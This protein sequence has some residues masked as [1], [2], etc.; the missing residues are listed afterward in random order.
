MLNPFP[1]DFEMDLSEA[2]KGLQPTFLDDSTRK[3]ASETL[4]QLVT[5]NKVTA[6][7]AKLLFSFAEAR[8]E[9]DLCFDS[10][11]GLIEHL[12]EKQLLPKTE[13]EPLLVNLVTDCSSRHVPTKRLV[14]YQLLQQASPLFHHFFPEAIVPVFLHGIKWEKDPQCIMILFDLIAKAS[15]HTRFT[16]ELFEAAFRYFPITYKTPPNKPVLIRTE[17]LKDALKRVLSLNPFLELLLPKLGEKILLWPNSARTDALHIIKSVLINDSSP[18]LIEIKNLITS[19]LTDSASDEPLRRLALDCIAN[20]NTSTW[21]YLFLDDCFNALEFGSN[22]MAPIVPLLFRAIGVFDAFVVERLSKCCM[23]ESSVFEG[24]WLSLAVVL[25]EGC[26]VDITNLVERAIALLWNSGSTLHTR[27]MIR[28]L[29]AMTKHLDDPTSILNVLVSIPVDEQVIK[30]DLVNFFRQTA[31]RFTNLHSFIQLHSN[32]TFVHQMV[33]VD[34]YFQVLKTENEEDLETVAKLCLISQNI[35]SIINVIERSSASKLLTPHIQQAILS[36]VPQLGVSEQES[37]LKKTEFNELHALLIR[38]SRSEALTEVLRTEDFIAAASVAN[39]TGRILPAKSYGE[40]SIFFTCKA[41]MLRKDERA[42][43]YLH[44]LSIDN[45]QKLSSTDVTPFLPEQHHIIYEDHL[46][47]FVTRLLEEEAVD[48]HFAFYNGLA[49]FEPFAGQIASRLQQSLELKGMTHYSQICLLSKLSTHIKLG[50]YF[51][52]LTSVQD[53]HVRIRHAA[54]ECIETFIAQSE[55]LP[56]SE[57]ELFLQGMMRD[58]K[59]VVRNAAY[60]CYHKLVSKS[61]VI[62]DDDD[63]DEFYSE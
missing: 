28:V 53:S 12:I 7:H 10:M 33:V 29:L 34:E 59:A 24:L 40:D 52:V 38:C 39:K 30:E 57:L 60:N 55:S 1:L 16:T 47:W 5:T 15:I 50:P 36:L 61:I 23:Q 27:I 48:H 44:Q 9:D 21:R 51:K 17:D 49:S 45:I 26:R 3:E 42:I 13:L 31:T 6:L 63:D 18:F 56:H 35:N 54:I 37:C 4:L 32:N 11:I 43:G 20:V 19:V 14:I 41:L 2:V 46:Q 58:R 62:N 25:E 8:L 22:Q